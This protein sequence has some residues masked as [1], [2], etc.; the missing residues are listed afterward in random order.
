[1]RNAIITGSFDPITSGHA[2]LIKRSSRIFD[3]VTVVVVGNTEKLVPEEI[4]KK[5]DELRQ[6]HD[7]YLIGS[8]ASGKTSIINR[9]IN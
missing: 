6:G 4:F 5:M 2:Y 1:M 9:I 7:V 3:H 8:L